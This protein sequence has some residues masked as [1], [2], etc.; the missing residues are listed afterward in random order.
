VRNPVRAPEEAVDRGRRT[1]RVAFVSDAVY[2]FNPGGK[3]RRLHEVTTRLAA[4]GH[5]VH[6]FTMKWW[7]GPRN[8]VRDGIHFHAL[9]PHR[10]LYKGARRSTGQAVLFGLATLKLVRWRFDAVDV[11]HMPFFP[12][13]AM[14]L[15]CW[16]RGTRFVATWHEVWGRQYW[17]EYLGRVAGWVAHLV[18]RFAAAMPDEIV[19]VSPHTA[20]RL[21]RVLRVTCPVTTVPLG[22][23]L[24]RLDAVTPAVDRK[25][26]VLF[27]GRLLANKNVDL[28]IAAVARAG[29]RRP[30]LRCL[31]V[32]EGPERERLERL[33]STLSGDHVVDFCGFLP[34]DEIYRVMK[35]AGVLVL[36]SSREG[37]GLV[38]AEASACGTPVVTLRHP[39]NAAAALVD[40]GVNGV[41]SDPDPDALADAITA[42]LATRDSFTPR[43]AVAAG[44]RLD[45]AHTADGV[46]AV[47]SRDGA[48]AVSPDLGDVPPGPGPDGPST[49]VEP[50][51]LRARG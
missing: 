8:I 9:I 18:E 43:S 38:V 44:H 50:A 6:V 49:L 13:F 14:R 32:G 31:V 16:A 4:R 7:A 47:L 51:P 12:L 3:E 15:V 17:T 46:L 36:P 25:P 34:G 33:A 27:A 29:T 39:D 35:A 24:D 5:E 11:D 41:V 23:D 45:W 37:F 20:G 22:V 26:D 2:P 42:V 10:A 21:R 28:L 19:A 40:I 48:P 30:G 1:R